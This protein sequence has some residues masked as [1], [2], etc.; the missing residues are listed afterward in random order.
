MSFPNVSQGTINR[1]KGSLIFVNYPSLNITAAFLGKDGFSCQFSSP[2]TDRLPTMT[3]G[4]NSP[5]PYRIATMS[6]HLVK[7]Q[8]LAQSWKAQE[9]SK[10]ILGPAT[11]RPDVANFPP[12]QFDNC[13]LDG[14]QNLTVNGMD[15]N[16]V[17]AIG[18]YYYINS[19]M[20]G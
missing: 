2:A 20:W 4:V 1:L 18:G 17:I 14:I 16:F 19:V 13:S 6:V 12:Y 5:A 10:T 11:F 7:S 15:P 9:E 3:G 8:G